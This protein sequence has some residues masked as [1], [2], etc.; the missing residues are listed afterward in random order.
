VGVLP[1]WKKMLPGHDCM[2]GTLLIANLNASNCGAVVLVK[3]HRIDDDHGEKANTTC[4]I[5]KG[6]DRQKFLVEVCFTQGSDASDESIASHCLRCR[7]A[8]YW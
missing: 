3:V 2:F 1:E 5:K 8:H 6:D 7:Y 4:K